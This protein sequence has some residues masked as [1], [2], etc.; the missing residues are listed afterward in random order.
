MQVP[1]A[2]PVTVAP[3]TP[4]TVQM[5]IVVLVKTTALPEAPPVAV[6]VPVPPTRTDGAVPKAMACG[7]TATVN[8]WLTLGAAGK[9]TLPAWFAWIVQEPAATRVTVAPLVP[10]A[11]QIVGVSDV[12]VTVSIDEAV[13][14]TVNGALPK[15]LPAN[16]PNVMLFCARP[17][18]MF[19][20]TCGAAR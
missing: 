8:D 5:P 4:L 11:V 20:V 14:L 7:A 12:K 9:L 13:A 1:T 10:V 3:L 17:T 19:C 2:P 6:T 15:V 16:G 18:V